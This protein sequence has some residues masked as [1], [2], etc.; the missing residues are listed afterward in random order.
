M[1]RV[2]L[3]S[4]PIWT[5]PGGGVEN[6]ES[7]LTAAVRELREETGIDVSD[8]GPLRLLCID[9]AGAE[10]F[11]IVLSERAELAEP[12]GHLPEE[13]RTT[14]AARWMPLAELADDVQVRDVI[15]SL[16]AD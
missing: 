12:D 3:G 14:F 9:Q 6:G 5:L 13:Q 16:Q 15:A 11:V 1:V 2:E 8:Q 4:G 7:P 10:V